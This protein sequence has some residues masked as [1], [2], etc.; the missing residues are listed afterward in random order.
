MIKLTMYSN[1]CLAFNLFSDLSCTNDYGVPCKLAQATR[2]IPVATY[3]LHLN[4]SFYKMLL[5]LQNCSNNFWAI[6]LSSQKLKI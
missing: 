2:I 5:V 6:T 1:I 4:P 3:S